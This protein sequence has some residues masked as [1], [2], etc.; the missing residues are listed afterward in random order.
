MWPSVEPVSRAAQT[1]APPNLA[2]M[3]EHT[4]GALTLVSEPLVYTT[5][6]ATEQRCGIA[7]VTSKSGSPGWGAFY[8]AVGLAT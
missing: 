5:E 3:M 2:K 6:P 7:T 1:W 8:V 4:S